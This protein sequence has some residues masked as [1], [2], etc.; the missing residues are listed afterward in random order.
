MSDI[1][2]NIWGVITGTLGVLSLPAALIY[3]RFPSR[4]VRAV[5]RFMVETTALF[6]RDF[7]D[8]LH[9]DD[10]ELLRFCKKIWS[11]KDQIEDM[12]HDVSQLPTLYARVKGCWNGVTAKILSLHAEVEILRDELVDSSSRNRKR[13]AAEGYP[14][15][16][17]KL[18]S[19]QNRERQ[20]SIMSLTVPNSRPVFSEHCTRPSSEGD[21][22][23]YPQMVCS[24]TPLPQ[25]PP[26]QIP[27]PQAPPRDTSLPP[28]PPPQTELPQERLPETPPSPIS[29]R[30][31]EASLDPRRE[32]RAARRDVL[33]Q[34]SRQ[35]Y[36]ASVASPCTYEGFPP[37]PLALPRGRRR[38]RF[39]EFIQKLSRLVDEAARDGPYDEESE[40]E[41]EV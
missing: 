27:L 35:S 22:Q 25:T 30:A 4:K 21:V 39:K 36:E 14:Q 23:S 12:K 18:L 3:D 20:M 38:I 2:F 7:N 31:C 5:E 13:L 6:D 34:Y 1:G 16:L 17:A 10:T 26:P 24:P 41:D 29:S 40:D 15:G 28:S 33:C 9:T 11:L 8:G 19:A 32:C 37:L